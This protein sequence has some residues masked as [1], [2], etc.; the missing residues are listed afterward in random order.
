METKTEAVKMEDEQEQPEDRGHGVHAV[1][2]QM[3]LKAM[4]EEAHLVDMLK[5]YWN[6]QDMA[7]AGT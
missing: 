3:L 4:N 6:N 2:K 1:V 5:K 7:K